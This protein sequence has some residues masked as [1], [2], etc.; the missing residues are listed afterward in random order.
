M[1]VRNSA[2]SPPS[3]GGRAYCGPQDRVVPQRTRSVHGRLASI[4]AMATPKSVDDYLRS[5]PEPSRAALGKLRAQI[6]AAAPHATEVISYQMPAFRD[7]DL[8]LVSYAAFKDH[9]SM[10]PMSKAAI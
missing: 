1:S 5:V 2:M 4:L 6:R 8:L 7:G 9:C 10:F 3:V